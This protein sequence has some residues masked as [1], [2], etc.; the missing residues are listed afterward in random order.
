M[1]SLMSPAPK[2]RTRRPSR[3]PPSRSA[4]RAT[5][6]CDM[7]VVPLAMRVSERARLP[8]SRAWRNS[9]ERVGPAPPSACARSHASRTWP[10]ISLSPST[11]ESSPLATSNRWEAA[12]SP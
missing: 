10:R 1:P 3:E 2:S 12:A 6:A 8:A 5:A 11:A 9:T 7:E 4:A